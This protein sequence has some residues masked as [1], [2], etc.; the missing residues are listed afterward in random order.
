LS[1]DAMELKMRH[2]FTDGGAGG[3]SM[4]VTAHDSSLRYKPTTGAGPFREKGY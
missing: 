3:R 4:A 1:T 2:T